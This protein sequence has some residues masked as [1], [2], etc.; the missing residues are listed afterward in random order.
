MIKRAE[1]YKEEIKNNNDEN[2]N[3]KADYLIKV[4]DSKRIFLFM[5]HHNYIN[6]KDILLIEIALLFY[7]Y[8]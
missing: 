7:F 3:L 6:L 8:F 1:E 2:F 5:N 4:D